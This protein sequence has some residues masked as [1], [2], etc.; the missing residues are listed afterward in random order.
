MP[1]K[2]PRNPGPD[3]RKSIEAIEGLMD[4][5]KKFSAMPLKRGMRSNG[6]L[7]DAASKKITDLLKKGSE[8]RVELDDLLDMAKDVKPSTR[9]ERFQSKQ[10]RRVL[11]R[12]LETS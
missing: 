2:D 9:D 7:D 10:A 1:R 4:A 12:Y 11:A 6:A 3:I 8:M 5:L